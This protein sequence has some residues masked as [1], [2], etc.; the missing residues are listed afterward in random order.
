MSEKKLC[1]L[2]F[3]TTQ[4]YEEN[5][6]TL[7]SLI[8]Q[9]PKNSFIVAPEVCL[10]GYDYDNFEKMVA[11]SEVALPKLKEATKDKTLI[12]TMLSQDGDAVKNFAYVFHKGEIVRK[13]PKVKLFKFG[14]EHHYIASGNEEDIDIFEVDG[15]KVGVLI[16]FELRFK[17]FWQKLEGCD[18]IAVP[19]WWGILREQNY[20]I[21]TTALAIMNQCYVVASDSQNAICTR[22]SGVITPFGKEFRNEGEAIL[23]LD[24][25]SQEIKKMRRYMD[26]GI[27]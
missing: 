26:V 21:L 4:D 2:L 13:Q 11:F 18:I 15:L 9:S 25:D 24:F 5:L 16:C 20:K 10:T 7:L 23:K 12:L 17:D 8:K 3:E 19:S 14:E 27:K 1:S 22:A 6:K